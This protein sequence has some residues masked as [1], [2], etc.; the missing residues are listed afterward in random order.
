MFSYNLLKITHLKWFQTWWLCFYLYCL[1]FSCCHV[2]FKICIT[3]YIYDV[4]LDGYS[5]SYFLS[6]I[7]TV[8]R[9]DGQIFKWWGQWMYKYVS[10]F[11]ALGSLS[12]QCAYFRHSSPSHLMFRPFICEGQP[13]RTFVYRDGKG[14]W[15]RLLLTEE[16]ADLL[17]QTHA[18]VVPVS[19]RRKWPD[20]FE[21]RGKR[22]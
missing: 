22:Q 2:F 11:P 13:I 14:S 16:T 21:L 7:C 12:S 4:Y 9:L 10:F 3:L 6:Y 1:I 18:S 19:V 15:N 5:F 8:T 17:C 20:C